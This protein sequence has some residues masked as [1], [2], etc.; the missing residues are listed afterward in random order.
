MLSW[1]RT[2]ISRVFGCENHERGLW[3]HCYKGWL[4]TVRILMWRWRPGLRWAPLW[5]SSM[6]YPQE[7]F[8]QKL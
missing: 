2:R 7:E 3:V 5:V 1:V 4:Q 8:F 6:R